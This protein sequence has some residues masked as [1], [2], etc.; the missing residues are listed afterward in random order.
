MKPHINSILKDVAKLKVKKVK[1]SKKNLELINETVRQQEEVL[2]LK[3]IP[4]WVWNMR[5]T[6]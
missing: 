5:I 4:D 3:N 6:I 1:M 2:K